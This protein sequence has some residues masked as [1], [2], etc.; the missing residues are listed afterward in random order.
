M[1]VKRMG[2]TEILKNIWLFSANKTKSSESF[3]KQPTQLIVKLNS[4]LQHIIVTLDFRNCVHPEHLLFYVDSDLAPFYWDLSHKWNVFWVW[5]TFSCF[6]FLLNIARF[7]ICIC[8]L[9]VF[10]SKAFQKLQFSSKKCSSFP[11][12]Y[13]LSFLNTYS[14]SLK[15]SP[16]KYKDFPCNTIRQG[17]HSRFVAGKDAIVAITSLVRRCCFLFLKILPRTKPWLPCLPWRP[18]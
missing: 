8:G 5:A 14:A 6:I 11:G 13:E 16:F 2:I 7:Y 17:R 9:N 18:C 4:S 10:S 15:E 12:M 3:S 1:K